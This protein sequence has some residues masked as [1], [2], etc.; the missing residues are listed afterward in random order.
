MANWSKFLAFALLVGTAGTPAHAA[1]HEA[2]SKHFVI[3][4]DAREGEIRRFAER[5]ERID[6]AVRF[7]RKMDDPPLT[8]S[9][10]LT[11]FMLT[12]QESIAELAGSKLVAGF[13]IPR[14]TGA[15]AFVPRRAGSAEWELSSE[16][17]FIHEY[18]HHLQLQ[19]TSVALPEWLVEGFAEFFSTAKVRPDGSVD[20][21]LPPQ[22]RGFTLLNTTLDLPVEKL[23]VGRSSSGDG[24]EAD[25]FY[26]RSWTLA[27]YLTFRQ[28][29]AG[30]LG[31]YVAGIHSGQAPLVAAKNAFGDLTKLN[32]ELSQY[33]RTSVPGQRVHANVLAV[34]NIQTRQLRAGEA[35]VMDVRIRSTRGVDEKTAPGVAADARRI[36][37]TY[38]SEPTVQIAL[39]E[40]E[41]DT[42]NYKASEVA[43]DRALAADPRNVPAMIY[44]GRSLA[45][46]AKSAEQ[47]ADWASI[48]GWFM[49]ANKVDVE[50]PEPLYRYY[51]TFLLEGAKPPKDAVDALLYSAVLV[52]QD[53]SIRWAAVQQLLIDNKVREA[54]EWFAPLAYDPH[55]S[56]KSR[57]YADKIMDAMAKDDAKSALD[58]LEKHSGD[59]EEKANGA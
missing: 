50:A 3:F 48:R 42:K 10:K 29:R 26:G 41:F 18:A 33:I 39:A 45:E 8:D 25:L 13:Y 31:R 38:T 30:Q 22:H 2:K 20:I 59:E 40:A 53:R 32:R 34:G 4:G 46:Q 43:A 44:K 35:A 1:W 23:I 47:A 6:Q 57:A 37:A 24:E 51:E 56:E 16:S 36:A 54:R 11:I 19:D 17:I 14:V 9:N 7:V 55:A 15:V 28:D 49:R 21:G 52:P 5:L 58:L 27:H 12:D